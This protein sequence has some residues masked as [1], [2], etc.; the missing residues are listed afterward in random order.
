M[1][2]HNSGAIVNLSS[3]AALMASERAALQRREGRHPRVHPRG[4]REVA[5]RGIRVNAIAPATSTRR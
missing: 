4:A 3:V 2:R 1:S 5:S